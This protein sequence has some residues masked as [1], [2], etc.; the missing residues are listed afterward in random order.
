ML[1]ARW[2]DGQC[3][4]AKFFNQFRV[5]RAAVDAGA[6]EDVDRAAG[7][8]A[9]LETAHCLQP[10]PLSTD[11][12]RQLAALGLEWAGTALS[13]AVAFEEGDQSAEDWP[14]AWKPLH[15]VRLP[16][17]EEIASMFAERELRDAHNTAPET[18][19]ENS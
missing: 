18:H 3:P 10:D 2:G 5:V 13:E 4:V 15:L 6:G 8:R 7:L 11:K 9:A 14:P 19:E 12:L 16:S 1:W 17:D